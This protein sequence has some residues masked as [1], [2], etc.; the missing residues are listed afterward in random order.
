MTDSSSR[1]WIRPFLVSL[2]PTF[3][4]VLAISL[5]INILALAVP[6]FVLQVYDRVVFQG[7]LSTLQ[8]LVI[9]MVLVVL[10]DY[11]LR[12]GRARIM[13]TMAAHSDV[14]VGRRLF[15]KL[16]SL[17]LRTLESQPAASWHVLFRD[18]DVV[19]NTVSGASAILIADL[20]FAIMF[21]GLTFVIAAPVAWILLL[22]L[23]LFLL[24]AWRS[25]AVMTA[26]SRS[27]RETSLARERLVADI[28]GGRTTIKALAL[29]ASMEPVWEEKHAATIERAVI[30]GA[31]M[32]SYANLGTTLTML[33][34][35]ALTTAG[36]VAIINHQLTIGA[37]IATNLLAGR[38]VGPLTQ[39]VS[40]WRIYA[41]FGDAAGRLG[42]VFAMPSER[43]HS[44][45][46]MQR[47]SGTISLEGVSYGYAPGLRAVVDNVTLTIQPRCMT[48]LIG[49]NGSGKTTLLRLIQGLYVPT[50]GRVMLDGGD[51]TQF[52]REQIAGWI[53][54]VPQE[55]V[56]FAG[57]LRDNIAHRSPGARDEDIIAAAKAAD[58]HEFILELPDGY[59]SDIGEAGLRLSAGQ[60]QRI[61]IARALLGGPPVLLLDEPSSNLD[62]QSE[63]ELRRTLCK[64][65]AERTV[66]IVTHS[67]VLLSVCRDLVALDRG[68]VAIAGLAA[69]VLPRLM[70]ASRDADQAAPAAA[71]TDSAGV[72]PAGT[73]SQ[74]AAAPPVRSRVARTAAPAGPG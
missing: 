45:I 15:G 71:G 16:M 10:F 72:S 22:A 68:R 24:V 39:L 59:G 23:P 18:V 29:G 6:V 52:S 54:Y 63:F 41:G 38:L 58:A 42:R 13:Q 35:V 28:V 55:C 19:R 30:R 66:I 33:T 2:A 43:Q 12:Q 44:T 73:S 51:I 56:L 20:P 49:R 70:G 4:E 21:L 25:G 61:A 27:E 31:R 69:D 7:G 74:T 57:T 50:T 3:R 11:V 32:D 1:A 40:M 65:A 64:L 67:P 37:L 53:G 46:E 48:A 14:I 8:G 47:P 62:R 60:R 17:P 9:G 5:F 36:A 26:A 34:T